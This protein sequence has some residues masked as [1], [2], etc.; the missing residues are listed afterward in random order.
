MLAI[1]T[2]AMRSMVFFATIFI[3]NVPVAG[4]AKSET[5][6]CY[7]D[8]KDDSGCSHHNNT[9]HRVKSYFHEPDGSERNVICGQPECG[10]G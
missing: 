4:S 9:S 7:I 5:I 2:P 6:H 1:A 8:N 3:L 10:S